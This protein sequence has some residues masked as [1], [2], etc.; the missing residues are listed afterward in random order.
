MIKENKAFDENLNRAEVEVKMAQVT[1]AK[2]RRVI[3]DN[4]FLKG[5]KT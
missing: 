2:K 5:N 4:L 1:N 3:L